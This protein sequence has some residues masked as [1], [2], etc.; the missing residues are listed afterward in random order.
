[1][2]KKIFSKQEILFF[3]KNKYVKNVIS[4]GITYTN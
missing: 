4:K 1:M 2:N 3:P